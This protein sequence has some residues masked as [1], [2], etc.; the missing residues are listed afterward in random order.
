MVRFGKYPIDKDVPP[1][2]KQFK[3]DMLPQEAVELMIELRKMRYDATDF[4]LLE[5]SPAS[6]SGIAGCKAVYTM[7]SVN[8]P[9]LKAVTYGFCIDEDCYDLSYVAP[10]RYYFDKHAAEFEKII[11]TF[12][13]IKP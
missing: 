13:L 9:K 2:K 12:K 4:K 10:F 6:I 1:S 11:S 8:E 5:I 7:R 3:K